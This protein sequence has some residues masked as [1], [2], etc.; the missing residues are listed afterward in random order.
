MSV[1]GVTVSIVAFQAAVPGSTPGRRNFLSQ[2]FIAEKLQMHHFRRK[3]QQKRQLIIFF[4][5]DIL[6]S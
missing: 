2:F 3:K 1:D 5:V 4:S 6:K